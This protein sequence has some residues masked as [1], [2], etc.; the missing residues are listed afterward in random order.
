MAGA[1]ATT[2]A[3]IEILLAKKL[4]PINPNIDIRLGYTYLC[5][6]D[7][8]KARDC[9]RQAHH[10]AKLH[11]YFQSIVAWSYLVEN[12]YDRAQLEINKVGEDKDGYQLKN[13]TQGYLHAKLGRPELALEQIQLI[14]QLEEKEKCKFP[15][16]NLS[17][18]YA[19]LNKLE[20]MFYHLQKAYIEKPISLMFIRADPFWEPYRED[21][22]F[23]SLV[24]K[25]F[26]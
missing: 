24:D 14:N 1:S 23:I 20:E 13:G 3:L 11:M 16:F 12:R 2:A 5:L 17:L 22:R 8:E 18:V 15:N 9:F 25:I 7:F 4:D 6:K 10:V 21:T 26:N 19:G